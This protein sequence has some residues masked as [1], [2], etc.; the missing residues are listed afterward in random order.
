MDEKVGSEIALGKRLQQ[1][2]QGASL[3]QQQLCQQAGL[4]YSTLAKIERG[5]IKSPSI[6][7]IAQIAEVLNSSLDDLIGVAKNTGKPVPNG[8]SKSGIRFAFFDINGCLVRFFHRAFTQLAEDSGA[9]AD[10]VETAFWHYNDAVCRGEMSLDEFNHKLSEQLK[11]SKL[12]WQHYYMDAV[13]PISEMNE[14]VRWASQHYRVG[15]LSNIMPGFIKDMQT[16]GLIPDINYSCIIDSS[17]VKAIKP[18]AKIYQIAQQ[19]AGVPAN[20]ILLVDDSRANVMAAEKHGWHVLWFDDYR[21]A[22][23]VKRVHTAL[24]LAS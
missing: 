23:S 10:I 8:R 2:R 9:P 13:D 3:T 16:R 14:L 5:A 20:E 24:E 11:M 19:Q 12:D 22:E 6:F 1:A 18:E 21:P 4:S 17:E 7:T 15:L